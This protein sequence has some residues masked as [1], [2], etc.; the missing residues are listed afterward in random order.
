MPAARL[1]RSSLLPAAL[2]AAVLCP[3]LAAQTAG[4]LDPSFGSGGVAL[5]DVPV[6]GED[7]SNVAT[8]LAVQADGKLVLGGAAQRIPPDSGAERMVAVRLTRA[9]ALDATFGTGGRVRVNAF[10]GDP[11]GYWNGQV[12]IGPAGEISLLNGASY[13]G[14]AV[15]WVLA[16]LRP[17]GALETGF[18][19]GGFV[20]YLS[21]AVGVGDVVALADGKVLVLDDF[22]DEGAIPINQEL[23]VWRLLPDGSEDPSFGQ[24]GYQ[25]VGFNLGGSWD[26][27]AHAMALQPDGKILIAG[28]AETGTAADYDFAVARLTA[29]G[30]LDPT[31]SGDGRTTIG[32]DLPNGHYDAAHAIAVDSQ[33]RILVGGVAGGDCAV[34]RLLPDGTLDPSFSGDGRKTFPFNSSDPGAF[35]Q[36][37]GLAVQGDGRVVVAGRGT[38]PAG[39]DR[40]FALARLN[41][42]GGLDTTFSGDGTRVYDL[43][44]GSGQLSNARAVILADDG[45][46]LASGGAETA[47]DDMAFV[48]VKLWNDYVFADGFELGSTAAWSVAA[49]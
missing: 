25:I 14:G 36:V 13:G 23:S 34:A 17:T 16:R 7:F 5:V 10:P 15:G 12:A 6:G 26:D 35:D 43:A 42:R 47:V 45:S 3:P 49:P 37:F 4:D 44:T 30:Q 18:G 48:A 1:V 19:G 27:A 22:N 46:I 24:G 9:G 32:F 41:A 11:A 20:G 2:A 33:G 21:D 39:T 8:D 38:T 29:D 40:R 31:F 28:E